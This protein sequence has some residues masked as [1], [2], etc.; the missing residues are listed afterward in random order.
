MSTKAKNTTVGLK[1]LRENMETYIQRVNNGES[2]TVF[3]RST[4]LF[5]LTPIDAEEA[6]WETI[7]DFTKETGRGV[8]VEELL[9]SMKKMHG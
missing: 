3:R 6:G 9:A 5:K 1:E 4:P 8:P 7:V 2:I